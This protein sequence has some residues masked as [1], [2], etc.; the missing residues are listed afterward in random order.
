MTS[1][2]GTKK[3]RRRFPRVR[4]PV[5]YRSSRLFPPRQKV[6]NISPAGVRIFSDEHLEEGKRLEIE[7]FLPGGSSI[8]ATARVI[9]T[10]ELPPDSEGKYDVGLEFIHI[11]PLAVNEL[12][13][14]LKETSSEK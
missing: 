13:S 7:F 9:W 11:P 4:A 2:R 6:S 10:K 14:I 1:T 5:F 3:D 12:K 8:V